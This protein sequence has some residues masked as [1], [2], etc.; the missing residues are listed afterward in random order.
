M[1]YVPAMQVPYNGRQ[2]LGINIGM[3]VEKCQILEL[4]QSTN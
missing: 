1:R 4:G 2:I 3:T